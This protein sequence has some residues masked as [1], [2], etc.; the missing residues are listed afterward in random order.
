[1]LG[2]VIRTVYEMQKKCGA[3][4]KRKG[5]KKFLARCTQDDT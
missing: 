1:M 2:L 4:A 3:H 5:D